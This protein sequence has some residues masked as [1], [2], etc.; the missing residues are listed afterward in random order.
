MVHDGLQGLHAYRYRN[1][2]RGVVGNTRKS[3]VMNV[4]KLE[5]KY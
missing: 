3:N 4:M 1:M 5:S 2:W